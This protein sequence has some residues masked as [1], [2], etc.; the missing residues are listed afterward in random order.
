MYVVAYAIQY[1]LSTYV[2]CTGT[3]QDLDERIEIN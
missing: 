2:L 3:L 1:Q